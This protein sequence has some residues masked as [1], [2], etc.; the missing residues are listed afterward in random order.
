[1]GPGGFRVPDVLDGDV[2]RVGVRGSAIFSADGKRR[3]WFCRPISMASKRV[4]LMMLNPSDADADDNDPTVTRCVGFAE[5]EGAGS[6]EVA[7]LSDYIETDSKKLDG[8]A[9]LGVLS[10]LNTRHYQR[11]V[12]GCD[13]VIC[14]WGA[15]PWARGK[16]ALILSQLTGCNDIRL[17]GYRCLGKT[18]TGAPNHPLYLPAS[19]PLENWP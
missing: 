4:G 14:A 7:N 1:M 17:M 9:R 18:K 5:R 8:L 19:K 13:L 6:L 10:D 3:R 11:H 15:H 12:L 16:L 2:L